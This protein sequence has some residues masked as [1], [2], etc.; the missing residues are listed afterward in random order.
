MVDVDA[1]VP[2]SLSDFIDEYASARR[3]PALAIPYRAE[4]SDELSFSDV[5]NSANEDCGSVDMQ[6]LRSSA[7]ILLRNSAPILQMKTALAIL[8]KGFIIHSRRYKNIKMPIKIMITDFASYGT[9]RLTLNF[10][11]PCTLPYCNLQLVQ[12]YV[13]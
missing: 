3:T 4:C 11:M 13:N 8:V 1:E 12:D 2:V 6:V 10:H 5:M 9:S 7:P